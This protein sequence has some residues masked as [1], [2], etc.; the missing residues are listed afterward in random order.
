[1]ATY[2]P[3]F[4]TLL[5][6]DAGYA[7]QGY[8]RGH[9]HLERIRE[10]LITLGQELIDQYEPALESGGV[11]GMEEAF[12]RMVDDGLLLV[13]DYIPGEIELGSFTLVEEELCDPEFRAGF[14]VRER[15]GRIHFRCLVD[16]S[17]AARGSAQPEPSL[18][19]VTQE[20][21]ARWIWS[22]MGSVMEG[23][24]EESRDSGLDPYA[25]QLSCSVYPALGP[26]FLSLYRRL[27]EG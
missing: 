12:F 16:G 21:M 5:G 9:D 19:P 17:G 14:R 8:F 24:A 6:H 10:E 2:Q 11:V 4:A 27:V 26:C 7:P 1:M 20:E 3:D 18:K 23:R 15:D 25:I 13:D 22:V